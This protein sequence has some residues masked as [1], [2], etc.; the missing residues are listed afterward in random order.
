M[1]KHSTPANLEDLTIILLLTNR[2]EFA[3]RW[4]FY[5]ERERPFVSLIIADGGPKPYLTIEEQKELPINVKYF[6]DGLDK[7]IHSMIT[8][9]HSILSNVDTQFVLLSSDDDFYLFNGV[10]CALAELKRDSQ[11]HACMGIVRDFSIITDESAANPSYGWLRF[12]D[13]LYSSESLDSDFPVTRAES[14]FKSDE[15]FWHAVYRT[16]TLKLAYAEA[17]EFEIDDFTLYEFF[18]NLQTSITGKLIR[19]FH[20]LYMLHQVHKGGEAQRILAFSENNK[21]WRSKFNQVVKFALNSIPDAPEYDFERI[22]K[23]R[24]PKPNVGRTLNL[25]PVLERIK[26][27]FGKSFLVY[28]FNHIDPF[29]ARLYW[30]SEVKKI[31]KFVR[32]SRNTPKT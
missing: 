26:Y 14:F 8:R 11:L 12:G 2:D 17:M 25:R 21:F 29:V 10:A 20:F 4:L 1:K 7:D 5:F 6:Y 13:Q 32:Y 19:R 22:S 15:S 16:N 28:L 24:K 30:N 31:V 3:Q 23:L 18:I 9:I 27:K